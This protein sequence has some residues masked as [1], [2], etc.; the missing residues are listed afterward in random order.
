MNDLP[1]DPTTSTTYADAALPPADDTDADVLRDADGLEQLWQEFHAAVTMTSRELREWL[2]SSPEVEGA[3]GAR[4]VP[5]AAGTEGMPL[6][7]IPPATDP[8]P[9]Q[10]AA[11]RVQVLLQSPTARRSVGERV[12]GVLGKRR[13][14]LTV[15]DVGAMRA[16]VAFVG[17]EHPDPD[18]GDLSDDAWRRRLMDVG[19]D[20]LAA[21]RS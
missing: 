8:T 7:G 19:H 9:E 21:P 16:V 3:G 2:G 6:P 17:R 15:D 11:A 20:P 10:V 14:D 1:R 18:S 12:T 4:P 13:G 5:P